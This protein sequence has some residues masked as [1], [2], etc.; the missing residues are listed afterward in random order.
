MEDSAYRN[1]KYDS[2]DRG[3]GNA[4]ALTDPSRDFRPSRLNSG[5]LAR[6]PTAPRFDLSSAEKAS[7]AP[8]TLC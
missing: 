7:A 4:T 5:Q 8:H 1:W 3:A 6:P 2:T